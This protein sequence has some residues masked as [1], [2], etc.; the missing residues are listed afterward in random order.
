M[1]NREAMAKIVVIG[2]GWAGIS[3]AL[4]AARKGAGVLL[5]ERMD[6]LTGTGLAGGIM[7]NNGRWTVTEEAIEMKGGGIFD[8]IDGVSIHCNLDFPGQ[9]HASIYDVTKIEAKVREALLM[10][11]VKIFMKE[12][13][14]DV[15]MK[16]RKMQTVLTYKGDEIEGDVFVD[17]TGSAGPLANCRRYGKG[18][19]GCVLRC[20]SFGGR[21]SVS[22]RAGIV[23][24]KIAAS[25]GGFGRISGSCSLL[26]SSI[27]E[28]LVQ[29]LHHFGKIEVPIPE[30]LRFLD[31]KP[32]SKTCPQYDHAGFR[33]KLICLDNGHAK[34]MV[35]NVPVD[36][37][38]QLPGFERAVYAD[39]VAGGIGNSIRY[40][41]IA[42]TDRF[43]KVRG[44]D[45]LFCGGEKIGPI[46]GHT[47]AIITGMI[48]GN[49]AVRLSRR[50][51]L[52]SP[53]R[54]TA[55][56]DFLHY[57]NR[58]KEKPKPL[59][60]IFTFSGAKYFSRMK[61]KGLYLIHKEQIHKKIKTLGLTE[62]F[63]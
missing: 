14:T 62:V 58:Q 57:V 33:E 32:N 13:I 18:C 10:A 46:A 63:D 29:K 11:G 52:F 38:R 4:T 2:G 61:K 12:R 37:L 50:K 55:M 21:I 45:N 47:E 49:N 56:G 36:E 44:V 8:I 25:G 16:N 43:L 54:D 23:E 17:T 30:E 35:P 6:M 51:K 59:T 7:R 5:L 40:L 1:S 20:P 26:K 60:E 41:S 28:N 15:I 53:P 27:S 24:R 19:A 39:P 31:A 22:E 3:A 9:S 42:P 48:A 34:L